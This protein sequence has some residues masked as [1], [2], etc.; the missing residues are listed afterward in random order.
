RRI[1]TQAAVRRPERVGYDDDRRAKTSR[2]SE[3][4]GACG[5]V[6]KSA[7]KRIGARGEVVQQ[8]NHR[9]APRLVAAVARRQINGDLSIGGVARNTFERFAVHYNVLERRGSRPSR[10]SGAATALRAYERGG[11]GHD[12]Y[13]ICD[14]VSLIHRFIP[15][16]PQ[17]L[18]RS[19]AWS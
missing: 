9:I 10:R 6:G 17:K 16:R 13:G 7:G 3:T 5:K 1:R 18:K 12:S 4:V 2:S 14:E 8:I 15:E 19:C 11:H